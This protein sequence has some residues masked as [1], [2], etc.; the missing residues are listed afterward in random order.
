MLVVMALVTT[1][2]TTPVVALLQRG[3][4]WEEIAASAP[5]TASRAGAA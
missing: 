1:M 5:G 4:A 2:A 3:A